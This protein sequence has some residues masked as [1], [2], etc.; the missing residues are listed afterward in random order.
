M[1]MS[2]SGRKTLSRAAGVLLA[3][4]FSL[5]ALCTG[6]CVR[7][8]GG[9][10]NKS[11]YGLHVEEDGTVT[12]CGEPFY[13]FGVNYFGAYARYAETDTQSTKEFTEGL[14]GLASY[15]VPFVRFP[16]GGY[17]PSYYE[18]YDSEPEKLFSYMKTVLDECAANRIGVIASLMWWDP[19]MAAHLGAKRSDM[20]R[21][22][23]RL[24][25]YA[26]K[27]VEDVVSRFAD[28]PAVWGWEIGNEYNLNADLCDK[29]LKYFLWP[30]GIPG[31]PSLEDVNGF[32][33][34]TSGELRT[35]YTEIAR[36]IRKYDGYRMITTGNGEMRPY[37]YSI[38]SDSKAMDKKTH[39]WDLSWKADTRGQ[40]DE[41]NAYLTPDPVDTV[42]FHLQSGSADGSNEY[43]LAFDVFGGS[44]DSEEYFKAYYEIAKKLKKACFFGEFGDM[45]DMETAPDVIEKFR[46][47]TDAISAS[48]IQIAAL[49]QFQDYTDEGVSGEKLTVLS[50]LNADLKELGRQNCERY[51]ERAGG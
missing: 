27:Y 15:N 9:I 33:Y 36:V 35:F 41:M 46:T 38:S 11:L 6:S 14:A 23:S 51:W 37:A 48:G 4:V 39:L 12:L 17:Y 28:H 50:E 7:S 5:G 20:G 32:D 13:G 10:M 8:E 16:L 31:M 1:I 21:P 24:V 49:W 34:Y 2:R 29:E 47:V 43:V 40:F 19:A 30:D 25:K 18:V 3:I 26:K 42:C 44:L 45:L 22:S